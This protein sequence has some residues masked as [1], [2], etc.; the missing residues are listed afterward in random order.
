MNK[1]F[2][3]ENLNLTRKSYNEEKP[4]AK[5]NR[6]NIPNDYST[7]KFGSGVQN[8]EN[9][10][11]KLN[12]LI[13]QNHKSIFDQFN[14]FKKQNSDKTNQKSI[15]MSNSNI[16]MKSTEENLITNLNNKKNEKL[17]LPKPKSNYNRK[18]SVRKSASNN[19]KIKETFLK[20]T[21]KFF[22]R[23]SIKENEENKIKHKR[24]SN[25]FT[26]KIMK[27]I[28]NENDNAVIKPRKRNSAIFSSFNNNKNNKNSSKNKLLTPVFKF[29][30]NK[31]KKSNFLNPSEDGFNKNNNNFDSNKKRRFSIFSG[32]ESMQIK[33][34]RDISLQISKTI[35]KINVNEMRKEIREL[36]SSEIN[37]IIEKYPTQN[38]SLFSRRKS[39]EQSS[40]G[41]DTKKM[42]KELNFKEMYQKRFRNLFTCKNLYDSLD[43]EENED[44]EKSNIYYIAPNSISCN[45]LDSLVL[46][47]SLITLIY[48]PLFLAYIL[49]N[50]KVHF[51]SGIYTLSNL[52]D[53]VY[54][55]DLI[56]GFFRAYY[57][58]EEVL[59]IKKRYMCLNYIK[60][61]F[62]IDLIEAIPFFQILNQ[63]QE[64]CDNPNC[65]NY[66]FTNNLK[67]TL[68]LLKILKII[69]I[70]NN[71]AVKRIDKYLSKINFFSDWK[72]LLINVFFI[73][74]GIH[75]ASCYFI[76]LGKNM[77]PNWIF[78]SGLH[79]QSFVDIY[80]AS[81]YNIMT[82]LTTVGYGD[83]PVTCHS[84]RIF[85]IFLLIVGTLS[86]SW[87][88]TYVSNYIKKNS[89]KY[90]V[91]EEKLK[92]LD[93]INF[94]YPNLDPQLY[95]RI[96]RYLN[97]NK[98]RYKFDVK[99]IL[100][101]L[102]SSIQN[103]LIIEIYKP[104]IKNFQFFKYL[105]NS[106]FFVKIVTSMKPILSIKDD[107]LI[108]EGDVIEDII[109]IKKGILSLEIGMN[110]D[111]PKQFVEDY[112]NSSIKDNNDI[113]YNTTH[114]L[115]LTN[116]PLKNVNTLFSFISNNTK[117]FEIKK[118]RKKY[119]KVIELRKNEHFGDALMILNEK[120]PVTIRVRSKRAELLFLQKTDATQISNVYP[121]IWK[122]IVNKSLHNMEQ[123]KNIIKKR[124]I[125]YC[126]LNDININP[127]LKKKYL[128]NLKGDKRV[129]FNN[130]K[131]NKRLSKKRNK[132][133]S[134]IK[135]VISEV[136]ES[137]FVSMKTSTT[138]KMS[139][140][141]KKNINTYNSISSS[142][143]DEDKDKNKS[144][145][146]K[147][148][149]KTLISNKN[150]KNNDNNT[151]NKKAE[152]KMDNNKIFELIQNNIKSILKG[153][154][155]NN[156]N[157]YK[158]K[159]NIFTPKKKKIDEME[160]MHKIN[161]NY[162]F[163]SH[164]NNSEDN[165]FERINEE[166]YFNEDLDMNILNKHIMMNNYDY[167]NFIFHQKNKF[168]ETKE[169]SDDLISQ[170]IHCNKINKLL[171]DDN[172]S[173]M[174][175]EK[176]L[177]DNKSVK[178]DD[179]NKKINI[180]NNIVINNSNKNENDFN[181]DKPNK[182]LFLENSSADSF[183][184]NSN[185]ENINKIANYKYADNPSFQL[186]AKKFI[187]Q[188]VLN[189]LKT[190]QSM[191]KSQKNIEIRNAHTRD[192]RTS[193]RNKQLFP[194]SVEKSKQEKKSNIN[195]KTFLNN[196][197]SVSFGSSIT[198]KELSLTPI[199][200]ERKKTKNPKYLGDDEGTFYAKIQ[201]LNG[202]KK[203]FKSKDKN[204]E[205][206]GYKY[207][208]EIT[209]NIE[210]NKQN[211]NNPE[212]Y[213]SGFFNKILSTKNII[214]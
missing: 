69:K 169:N 198:P 77:Y 107:I 181:Q 95:E 200:R 171:S 120:S 140:I 82:T 201:I 1:L 148:K 189:P 112:L 68:L 160:Q 36:E 111:N 165:N 3:Q 28:K 17:L 204:K 85:Q 152:N 214:K 124:I 144:L 34:L 164:K 130:I 35:C 116:M 4:K 59:I 71:S 45:I 127:E 104:I 103:N 114:T 159:S 89:E 44:L 87:L 174:N 208:D 199:N 122:R 60:G 211:L 176:I 187:I 23:K 25:L 67:Y 170:N 49:T 46:I 12:I 190:V 76:F 186:K 183:T 180:Y 56:T 131:V 193:N 63:G 93:E 134:T 53:I 101:S 79:S 115:N 168:L 125:L 119:I 205:K 70:S 54:Y 39:L 172:T 81:I 92:I 128:K 61:S 9:I 2:L 78:D 145:I 155:D 209:K 108:Q 179:G 21:I 194:R 20:N 83:V 184:I 26:S 40:F 196:R 100:D 136:D 32:R 64:D 157:K 18:P 163:N 202:S 212:E 88:L 47:A 197:N 38:K 14:P 151:N 102:P 161:S 188:M 153:N 109:F 65:N 72:A 94:N 177:I 210:K 185:Y 158:F 29:G 73:F 50:C 207:E 213:F 143:D 97:Y 13:S 84:E 74:S 129:T 31:K 10:Q 15:D 27:E 147:E 154:F 121:N 137:K 22:K 52:I 206:E 96:F 182:F 118:F 175:F 192:E 86:Y 51:F 55:I 98:S 142:N 80:I 5:N 167:N 41:V 133:K 6:L 132:F 37:K 123:I 110:L 195:K 19:N 173:E 105:E 146:E 57:N 24:T 113:N 203:T 7:K 150:I 191:K 30:D 139:N 106:D 117:K 141:S 11:K 135:T 90:K 162:K 43:D 149:E 58:F 62:L 138:P 91:Y 48:I 16:L 178:T 156:K 42:S 33:S 8:I 166:K 99:Y 75:L 126:E 66:A